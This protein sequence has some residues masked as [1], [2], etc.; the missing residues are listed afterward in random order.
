MN[1]GWGGTNGVKLNGWYLPNNLRPDNYN[2]NHSQKIIIN[3]HP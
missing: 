2:F 3:I 1:W